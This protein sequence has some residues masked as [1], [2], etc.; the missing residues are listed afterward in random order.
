MGERKSTNRVISC[1]VQRVHDL[2]PSQRYQDISQGGIPAYSE[3]K[4]RIDYGNPSSRVMDDVL[5]ELSRLL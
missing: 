5:D 4:E 1:R 2:H 3:H